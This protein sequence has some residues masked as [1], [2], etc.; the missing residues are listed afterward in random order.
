MTGS[1][2]ERDD[3]ACAGQG[4]GYLLGVDGS[5]PA[6]APAAAAPAADV[7][8]RLVSSHRA[9][10][11]FLEPRVDDRATAEDILQAA[12]V[13]AV[14]K[15]DTVTEPESA[16]AWFYR[17][18]RNALTDHYRRRAREQRALERAEEREPPRDDEIHDAVCAC[19]DEL[20]PTLEPSYATMVREVDLGGR[21]VDE[22]AKG[23]G[24]T[25]NNATVRL[26]RARRALRTRL[27]SSCGTCA[28]H[29]C[30]ECSCDAA[31][32]T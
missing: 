20:L 29:G 22:V 30:F 31:P 27:E 7:I 3:W 9:F 32:K 16:V 28:S 6:E 13:R 19:I 17:L 21:P 23:L 10:L 1:H 5:R 26:H 18:L 12:F 14:D 25:K 15:V 2:P 4:L 24:I 11:A 8:E